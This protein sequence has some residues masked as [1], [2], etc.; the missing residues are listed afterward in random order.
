MGLSDPKLLHQMLQ[1]LCDN[2]GN[3]DLNHDHGHDIL[4]LTLTL[5][6]TLSLTP[7][8]FLTLTVGEYACYQIENG[9]QVIQVF[10]S[11]AG[12]LSPRDYDE[13]ALPYQKQVIA[14]I[15][16]KHPEVPVIIYIKQVR[17]WS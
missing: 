6:R 1:T 17:R 3:P 8:L 2:I 4:T 12:H 11:W 7:S 14:K 5:S 15:K 16:S 10:D 9:A 13:F